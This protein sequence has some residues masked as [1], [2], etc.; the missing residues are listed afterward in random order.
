MTV[1]AFHY[2]KF[3]LYV[4]L[5][6]APLTATS[7]PRIR[8]IIDA[9][10]EISRP[11][12]DS[13]V[14]LE[15]DASAPVIRILT[16]TDGTLQPLFSDLRKVPVKWRRILEAENP[17]N[18][19]SMKWDDLPEE[20]HRDLI[21]ASIA[22]Q[23]Y[24]ENRVIEG[25]TVRTKLKVHFFNDTEFLGQHYKRGYH[26]IDPSE[27]LQPKVEMRSEG[28]SKAF[29]GVEMH[30]RVRR[31][32]GS[33]SVDAWKFKRL[34]R[35]PRGHQHV[36]MVAKIPKALSEPLGPRRIADFYRRVNL[37]AEFETILGRGAIRE[38]IKRDGGTTVIYFD[39][40]RRDILSGVETHL[41][42]AKAGN[43]RPVKDDY[44]FAWVG[45][46]WEDTYDKP[47][48]WGFEYRAIGG[49]EKPERMKAVLDTIQY[50]MV[51]E[52]YG[53]SSSAFTSWHRS[54]S[55]T[56]IASLWYDAQRSTGAVGDSP[57]T[58]SVS[59]SIEQAPTHLRSAIR[60]LGTGKLVDL[61]R[62]N[63]ALKMLIFD[64][65]NDPLF[66]K[67]PRAL[68]AIEEAQKAALTS[69][70]GQNITS[71]DVMIEFVRT[72]GIQE[73]VARSLG[74]SAQSP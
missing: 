8:C 74:L 29:G 13:S 28:D 40:L 14:E 44:K 33:T 58:L 27:F 61:I 67:S 35:L 65:S 63:E 34:L 24:W 12:F 17:R 57:H 54:H 49:D 9:A 16:T 42:A 19:L 11:K 71:E 18:P 62:E 15:L 4:L 36:H 52:D 45:F 69:L 66:Y 72:S 7:G 22:G 3:L 32:A 23:N 6:I 64:W 2:P 46:R 68:E 41:E 26:E 50:A 38:N 59:D 60:S 39:H 47:G 31:S 43:A 30:F 10:R 25:L 51:N 37:L 55:D 20:A 56:P 5:A 1:R 70:R 53:I 48:L 73:A 21:E